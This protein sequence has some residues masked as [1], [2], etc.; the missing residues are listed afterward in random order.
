M[1]SLE[2]QA[3]AGRGNKSE[4]ETPG[5]GCPSIQHPATKSQKTGFLL[6]QFTFHSKISLN[7]PVVFVHGNFF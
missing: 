5:P 7:L 1:A 6:P 4:L 2:E 3:A